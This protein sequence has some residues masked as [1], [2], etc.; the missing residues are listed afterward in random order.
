M[1]RFSTD[2][3]NTRITLADWQAQT[4]QDQHSMIADIGSLFV[5]P[6]GGDLHLLAGSQAIDA[7][8]SQFAPTVD[9]EGDA[10]P[11]G[12]GIDIGADESIGGVVPP[13]PPPSLFEAGFDFGTSDSPVANG[14]TQ[15]VAG[16]PY[17]ASAGYG[18]TTQNWTGAD[19]TGGLDLL[20]RDAAISQAG[21]FAVDLPSGGYDVT[22]TLGDGVG[23]GISDNVAVSLEGNSVGT[24]S[25][26]AGQHVSQTYHVD[27][28]DGQ[29]T[30]DLND[31]GGQ[32]RYFYL[33]AIHIQA[34][35]PPP[36][37]TTGPQGRFRH[38][39]QLR[40]QYIGW[41][42]DRLQRSHPRWRAANGLPDVGRS[43]RCHPA[44]RIDPPERDGI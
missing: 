44:Q 37:D 12:A 19:D 27:V 3:E 21:T 13:P 5:D 42:S 17:N 30:I 31:M 22:L 35:D 16:S 28:T 14:Y 7:G 10:R 8:T 9:F 43:E 29:L 34:T 18:W 25:A 1:D 24:L 4:G 20:A 15:V 2:N 33:N 40:G 39:D 36:A 23:V 41:F 26:L 11:Q 32:S 38:A 6:S